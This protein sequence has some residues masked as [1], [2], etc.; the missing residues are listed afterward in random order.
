MYQKDSR[1]TDIWYTCNKKYYDSFRLSKVPN[2]KDQILA[3]Y[4][5]FLKWPIDYVLRLQDLVSYISKNENCKISLLVPGTHIVLN[6]SLFTFLTS[7][8]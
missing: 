4:A 3:V 7:K 2:K 5:I 6:V 1:D 8:M